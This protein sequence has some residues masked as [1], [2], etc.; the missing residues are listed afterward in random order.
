ML[1]L[2]KNN[3]PIKGSLHSYLQLLAAAFMYQYNQLSLLVCYGFKRDLKVKMFNFIPDLKIHAFEA[4]APAR[5]GR[6]I[7]LNIM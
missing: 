3:D 2:D 5:L 7:D 4:R 6:Y 1:N